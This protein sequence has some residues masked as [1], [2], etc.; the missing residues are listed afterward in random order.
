LALKYLDPFSLVWIRFSVAFFFLFSFFL[1]RKKSPL[2]I[3]KNPSSL[4]LLA[5]LALAFNYFGYLKGVQLTGPSNAQVIIQI[6]PLLLAFMGIFFFKE[7]INKK[8]GIGIF[9][10]VFGFVL[11]YKDRF[12]NLAGA[13]LNLISGSLWVLAGAIS[14]AIYAISQK[15]LVKSRSPQEINLFIFFF[16]TLLYTPLVNFNAFHGLNNWVWFLLILLGLNTLF[17]YG[18]IGEAL[19]RIAANEVGVIITLNPLI[20]ITVMGLI[21]LFGFQFL[22]PDNIGIFGYFGAFIFI[23]GAVIFIYFAGKN[24]KISPSESETIEI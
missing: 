12:Q 4:S 3:L 7:R 8:Q 18:L 24:E 14:W 22:S 20:T 15:F 9:I 5:A 21:E 2:K 1:L 13:D 19:K 6:G 16:C 10:L 23:S 11:F 17:A